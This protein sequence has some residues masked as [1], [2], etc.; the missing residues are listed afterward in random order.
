MFKFSCLLLQRCNAVFSF[1]G[2]SSIPVS[3][4]INSLAHG[5]A[6]PASDGG[7]PF[8]QSVRFLSYHDAVALV[9]R[10]EQVDVEPLHVQKDG[11][12][13]AQEMVQEVADE[14]DAPPQLR[15]GHDEGGA[16]QHRRLPGR[17][18]LQLLLQ[19]RQED[20]SRLGVQHPSGGGH[21]VFVKGVPS[22]QEGEEPVEQVP[23]SVQAVLEHLGEVVGGE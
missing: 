19:V 16:L 21:D 7:H 13:R 6:R 15:H 10:P 5:S 2:T 18:Q 22:V 11:R 4:T 1:S 3:T 8:Q 17:L 23:L 14:R 9:Q 12:V 20:A